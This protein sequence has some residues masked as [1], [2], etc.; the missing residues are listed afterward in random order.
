MDF[1]IM[2]KPLTHTLIENETRDSLH[3]KK[4]LP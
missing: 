3:I 2:L 1:F 4:A